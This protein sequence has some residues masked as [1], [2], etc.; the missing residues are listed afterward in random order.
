MIRDFDHFTDFG[1]LT[2]LIMNMPINDFGLTNK[3]GEEWRALKAAI[4]PAF[5]LKNLKNIT[6]HVNKV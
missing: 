6:T 3:T 2:E 4:S 5:S 1:F